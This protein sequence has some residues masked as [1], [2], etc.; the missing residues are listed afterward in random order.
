MRLEFV[1]VECIESVSQDSVSSGISV[2][3]PEAHA[4]P[5]PAYA[6]ARGGFIRKSSGVLVAAISFAAVTFSPARKL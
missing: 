4:G 6:L 1:A 3:V 2:V 5:V